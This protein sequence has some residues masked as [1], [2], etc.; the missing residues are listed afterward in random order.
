MRCYAFWQNLSVVL[1]YHFKF[2]MSPFRLDLFNEF[3]FDYS[4]FYYSIFY[5]Q[6]AARPDSSSIQFVII[7]GR[8]KISSFW[9]RLDTTGSKQSVSVQKADS[10]QIEKWI[11]LRMKLD[12]VE[13]GLTNCQVWPQPQSKRQYQK[14]NFNLLQGFFDTWT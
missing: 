2:S 9:I 1:K 3:P 13:N 11:Q 12:P 7:S 14:R 5:H 6:A 10:N 4:M 8:F